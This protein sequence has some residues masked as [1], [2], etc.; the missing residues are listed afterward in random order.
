M[1][2]SKVTS[3][4]IDSCI[5][6]L[7]SGNLEFIIFGAGNSTGI[8]SHPIWFLER[9]VVGHEEYFHLSP[10]LLISDLGNMEEKNMLENV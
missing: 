7:F 1:G 10:T 4:V 6:N 8:F 9:E 5:C 3:N 2:R